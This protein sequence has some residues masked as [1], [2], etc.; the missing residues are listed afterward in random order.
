VRRADART[1][2][3]QARTKAKEDFS[4][5]LDAKLKEGWSVA[6]F[7]TA[8]KGT[9]LAPLPGS[10]NN[11]KPGVK[12]PSLVQVD[13]EAKELTILEAVIR[14]TNS[15][16]P[17]RKGRCSVFWGDQVFVPSAG[18]PASGAHHADI[19][20]CLG[21]MPSEAEWAERGLEKY[22]LIAVNK[23]GAAAQVEKVS[24]PTAAR[25]LKTFGEIAEVGPSLG[26]FSLSAELLAAL[27][28]EFTPELE[29]K[30]AKL[31]SDPHFWMPLTL[32]GDAYSSVM[33]QKKMPKAE[34]Q[35]HYTRMAAFKEAFCAK[36]KCDA[37]LG[38]IDAGGKCYWWDYGLL[39]LYQKNNL[40]TTVDS[41]EAEALRTFLGL[42]D[43]A[44]G[45]MLGAECDTHSVV[46]ASDVKAGRVS[47]S[48]LSSVTSSKVDVEGSILVNV[49]ARRVVGK[50][51]VLYNVVEDSEDGLDLPDGSVRADIFIP[52]TG[53]VVMSST[54]GTD[55]GQ[56][57][58][59]RL[60]GND[61]SFEE[62]YKANGA[63]DLLA[64]QKMLSEAR[65]AALASIK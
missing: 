10:E 44:Q 21:P 19:L 24:H 18:T 33:E 13:R 22:G 12:L 16:A 30:T 36:H 52:G 48:V 59:V 61:M 64:A 29:G 3:W 55:G 60:E 62:A 47:K 35:A 9:R 37:V 56:A 17:H 42:K 53:K 11:N 1:A 2:G 45:S 25:L 5:D 6:M 27:L 28:A 39:K 38:C 51:L 4:V 7:H 8:G 20:A 54:T 32:A 46:L 49:S 34:A 31:D 58:K 41:P 43:R 14:Q 15:Y 65:A 23:A 40:L 57:W 63:V 26:S 50:G